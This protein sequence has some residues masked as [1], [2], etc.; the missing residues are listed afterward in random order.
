MQNINQE[1][2]LCKIDSPDD[3]KALAEEDLD[4]LCHELRNYII[5][6]LSSNP[7][8]L[9]SSLGTV[10]LTVA[11][12]YVY[13]VPQDCL[14]WDVGHQAYAHK[15]LTGRR[16][17]F[18]DIRKLNGPSGFPRMSESVYDSFGTG[19][20]ST[21]I[22]AALAMAIA[23]NL[24]GKQAHHIAV[25]GDG[26]MTGG[27][28]FEALNHAGSTEA[29]LLVILND[30]G[31]SIDKQV[32]ALS[33]YLTKITTSS[34]YNRL[35]NKIWN[36]LGGNTDTYSKHKTIFKKASFA[37]KSLFSG[38]SN[39]FEAL[40]I[41]YFGPIDGNDVH[42]LVKT[43]S[44]LKNIKGPKLLHII[45]K[46][47]KG[48]DAAENNPTKYHAPGLFNPLTGEIDKKNTEKDNIPKFQDVFGETL[49][50][51]A[52]AH[53]NIAGITPAMLSGCSMNK[54][55]AVFPQR[56]FDVGIAE[57]HAVCLAAGFATRGIIPFCN[58]YSSFLQRAYDQIIHDIALQNLHVVLAIDRSGLVGEDG[59]THHGAFDLAYLRCIPNITIAV[60]SD[61]HDLRN[62]MFTATEHNGP[63][64]IRYP[65]GKGY[66][67]D[68]KNPM[69]KIEIGKGVRAR[70]G[71]DIAILTIGVCL[72]T[73]K[74]AADILAKEGIEAAV[75][76]FKFLKPL[77][78]ELAKEALS[79]HKYVITLED[80][81]ITGGFGSA[82]AEFATACKMQNLI[83]RMGIPDKFIEHGSVAQLQALCHTDTESVVNAAKQILSSDSR[84]STQTF[85]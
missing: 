59:A 54:L 38:K 32:G 18:E 40:N 81:C 39:F 57:Q 80:G 75:Y 34:T 31:I 69:H 25:I 44:D 68:W 47:G 60:P 70:Q 11:L 51:L 61:E 84:F 37:F 12:H 36:I 30:N 1:G 50:E 35:K 85:D 28:A 8:H 63:F 33:Q 17:A 46:K 3:L 73:A 52:K 14:V 53:D 58:V 79:E 74:K 49:V 23:D 66:L 71:K 43:L 45:T 24:N 6:I 65:R 56:T 19:H 16:K 29:D 22:S 21:S 77:D 62:M 42:T 26:S 20:S 82:I 27:M 7:G 55:Q 67:T 83:F 15:V 2:L 10:E 64:A 4:K 72:H 9:A 5:S 13:N 78:E 48:L 41:R 76:D